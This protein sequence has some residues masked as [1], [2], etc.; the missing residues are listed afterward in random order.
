MYPGNLLIGCLAT[1]PKEKKPEWID[2][3]SLLLNDSKLPAWPLRDNAGETCHE[4]MVDVSPIPMHCHI[5][6]VIL[7]ARLG[8]LQPKSPHLSTSTKLL[9]RGVSAI[10]PM[11]PY[12]SA[13]V[14]MQMNR[15]REHCCLISFFNRALLPCKKTPTARND[16]IDLRVWFLPC[17]TWRCAA[18]S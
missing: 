15:L 3:R 13:S 9:R 11:C 4:S 7:R 8:H 12:I 16:E 5:S 1:F 10:H 18:I 17:L 14:I 2:S 6:M